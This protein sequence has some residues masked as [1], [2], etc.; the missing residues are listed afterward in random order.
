MAKRFLDQLQ[1]P[2]DDDFLGDLIPGRREKQPAAPAK[3]KKKQFKS[4][5]DGTLDKEVTANTR[6]PRKKSF[7]GS[8]EAALQDNAFDEVIPVGRPLAKKDLEPSEDQ[9]KSPFS[10]MIP[11]DVL[12]R[13][14]EIAIAKSI[15]VSDVLNIALKYYLK[16]VKEV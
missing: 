5:L 10:L 6:S 8:I 9:R 4:A 3:S 1:I 14:R 11:S 16:N 7:L 13:A 2:L 15:R 12:E